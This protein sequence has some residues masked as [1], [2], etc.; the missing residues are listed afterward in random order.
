MATKRDYY[1]VLSVAR[2]A[3]AAEIKSA[4]RKLAIQ[5]HPDRNQ[6]DPRAEEVFKEA[7]ELP[8]KSRRD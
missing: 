1:E 8:K 3:S 2:E 5:Y 4:Y 6:G 7:A